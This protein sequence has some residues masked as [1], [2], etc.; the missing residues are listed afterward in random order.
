MRPADGAARLVSP[1]AGQRARISGD[2]ARLDELLGSLGC[3]ATALEAAASGTASSAPRTEPI[4]RRCISYM[5][6]GPA[7]VPEAEQK[8][9]AERIAADL[10]GGKHPEPLGRQDLDR[11][12]VGGHREPGGFPVVRRDLVRG[13]LELPHH[14][15][16]Q[17]LDLGVGNTGHDGIGVT[18]HFGT[19]PRVG[20]A[21]AGAPEEAPPTLRSQPPGGPRERPGGFPSPA[22]RRADRRAGCANRHRASGRAGRDG[23]RR[24]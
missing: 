17:G 19:L 9:A 3:T 10:S 8:E 15:L 23:I 6:N 22:A 1:G 12:P 11:G 5:K 13:E 16:G 21:S 2:P 20:G 24:S 7:A 18:G 14:A 4:I